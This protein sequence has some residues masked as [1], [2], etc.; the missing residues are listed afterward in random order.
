MGH[1][2][3]HPYSALTRLETASF[4]GGGMS[5]NSTFFW[6]EIQIS[7]NSLQGFIPG[8]AL[9]PPSLTKLNLGGSSVTTTDAI[10][11][12]SPLTALQKLFL[13][14]TKVATGEH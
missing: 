13:G 7:Q 9:L 12:L 4:T 11:T 10:A 1:A 8:R 14:Q 3:L 6:R 5:C 2:P